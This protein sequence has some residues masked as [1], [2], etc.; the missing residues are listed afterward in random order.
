MLCYVI[1]YYIILHAD[2][3]THTRISHL[4]AAHCC[5]HAA[6]VACPFQNG[7]G[8]ACFFGRPPATPPYPIAG[9]GL[10]G[11][12]HSVLQAGEFAR[13]QCPGIFTI[14]SNYIENFCARL[15]V[16]G[17]QQPQHGEKCLINQGILVLLRHTHTLKES[18]IGCRE[19]RLCMIQLLLESQ[20]AHH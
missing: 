20:T 5:A 16:R 15:L 18:M 2:T 17:P 3:D 4:Q 13:V 8:V 11:A 10:Q 19:P 6:L 14:H 9:Q 1:L 12:R 7:R